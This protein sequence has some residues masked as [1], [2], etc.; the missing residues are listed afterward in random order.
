[1]KTQIIKKNISKAARLIRSG[2][3]VAVPTETVYG[4]ACD[5][6]NAE[7]VGRVYDLKGRPPDKPLSLLVPGKEAMGAFCRDVPAA[8]YSL[9]D[10]FWPG[11]LTIV[12]KS[13]QAVPAIVT[14][15]GG[16]V[17]L[18]CPSHSLTLE[19]L[20]K[21]GL[22]LAAPSANPSGLKPPTD[23]REVSEYFG[24][25]IEAVI[26]GG[27]CETGVESTVI[28]MSGAP[29]RILR[30]GALEADEVFGAVADALNI[31][32]LTGGSGTGKTTAL[33]VSQDKGALAVDCDAIY[34]ELLENSP[35]MLSEID[36]RF[37]GV[38]KD[39]VLQRKELGQIVFRGNEALNDLNRIT[40]K[41]VRAEV[42][43]RLRAH[44]V[45]GGKTAV[46]DAIALIESGLAAKCKAVVGITASAEVRLLRITERESLLREYAR[47][48]IDAQKTDEFFRE[49][50]DFIIENN[51]GIGEFR[52]KCGKLFEELMS[53]G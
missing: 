39:G 38:V 32:G 49:N 41:Y 37:A 28:D 23:A 21:T 53:N 11:P 51:G 40:H 22:P 2:K 3:I 48:R 50:C 34:H 52:D 9:A 30:E 26:D 8:A 27:R 25:K 18:R 6:L 31:I 5:G 10:R 29:Y 19:L 45:A 20:A 44:A 7:A 24:G 43:T 14:A 17:G 33:K 47:M 15:G 16:T 4:L 36:S 35:D 13:S 12:L 42:D 46:V 1:M